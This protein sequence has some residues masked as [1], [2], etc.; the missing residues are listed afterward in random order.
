MTIRYR[1]ASTDDAAAIADLHVRSWR[2]TYR[3]SYRD[4]Y[5]DGPVEKER[6][7]V[8]TSR[9]SDPPADQFVVVAEDE[10]GIAGFACAYGGHD[11]QWG[12]FIENIHAD[13]DRHRQGIG[14]GLIASVVAWCREHYPQHGLHLKVLER[15][16]NARRFY[17][18]LGGV[19]SGSVAADNPWII[20]DVKVRRYAWATLDAVLKE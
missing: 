16:A 13:P 15:N 4:D 8:W 3:G 12:S 10:H 5:L 9:L 1:E 18:A 14:S 20:G 17:A 6:L 7:E 19:D 11:Q 2:A